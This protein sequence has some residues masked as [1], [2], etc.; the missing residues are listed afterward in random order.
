ML[1]GGGGR[2]CTPPVT[3]TTDV[4][5]E[6][7]KGETPLDGKTPLFNIP[8]AVGPATEVELDIGKGAVELGV[9]LP[10]GPVGTTVERPVPKLGVEG[11]LEEPEVMVPLDN[12]KE[13]NVEEISGTVGPAIP[14]PIV[15]EPI[16]LPVGPACDVVLGNGNGAVPIED[17]WSRDPVPVGPA[18][19]VLLESGNVTVPLEAECDEETPVVI[20]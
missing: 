5:L 6:P 8:V 20:G 17:G 19:E 7:G 1:L 9:K 11:L 12:G 18:I 10:P 13:V 4:E 2:P 3:E 15:V 16:P 14:E